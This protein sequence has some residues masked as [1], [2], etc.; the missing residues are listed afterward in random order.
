M[1][2]M[3]NKK[4]HMLWQWQSLCKNSQ[5]K[6]FNQSKAQVQGTQ[7]HDESV[8]APVKTA[9]QTEQRTNL[10]NTKKGGG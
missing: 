10:H 3:S 2:Q 4:S 5:F 1:G 6:S 7:F 8:V 9:I